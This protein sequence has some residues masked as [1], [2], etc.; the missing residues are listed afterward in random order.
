MRLLG[1][2]RGCRRQGG[3]H[4]ARGLH[5]GGPLNSLWRVRQGQAHQLHCL[6]LQEVSAQPSLATGGEAEGPHGPASGPDSKSAKHLKSRFQLN[7]LRSSSSGLPPHM[8]GCA[9]CPPL[10]CFG[11]W[12]S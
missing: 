4:T 2:A 8:V 3:A 12:S 5:K 11:A 10:L 7:A 1:F 9:P 6:W